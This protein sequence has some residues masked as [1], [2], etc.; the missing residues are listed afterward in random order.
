[1][2]RKNQELDSHKRAHEQLAYEIENLRRLLNSKQDQI[3]QLNNEVSLGLQR[4]DKL[5]GKIEELEAIVKEMEEKNGKLVDLIN[6]SIYQ[7][8][9]DYKNKVMNRL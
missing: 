1:M 3:D 2:T 8:A 5:N 9:E 4:E 7:K 6:N